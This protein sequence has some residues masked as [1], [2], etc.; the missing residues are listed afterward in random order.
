MV[1][2]LRPLNGL[3]ATAVSEPSARNTSPAVVVTGTPVVETIRA[4]VPARCQAPPGP[5]RSA[6]PKKDGRPG[7][8]RAANGAGVTGENRARRIGRATS[9]DPEA[10]APRTAAAARAHAAPASPTPDSFIKQFPARVPVTP[11]DPTP[12]GQ[13]THRAGAAQ[14]R[15]TGL[16]RRPS[17]AGAGVGRPGGTGR[18]GPS[19][20]ERRVRTRI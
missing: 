12:R 6:L 5:R 16:R 4:R 1:A 13:H 14:A 18:S 19:L 7:A 8:R 15:Y 20:G 2:R 17:R 3:T 9:A 10:A 11:E